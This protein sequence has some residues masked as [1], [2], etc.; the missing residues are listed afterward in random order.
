M[1]VLEFV[2]IDGAYKGR[3]VWARLNIVHQTPAAQEIA[4]GHLSAICRAVGVM[5]PRDSSELHNLPLNI[6]V[7]CKPR[8]DGDGLTN[9]IGR[10]EPSDGAAPAATAAPAPQTPQPTAAAASAVS[11]P[12]SN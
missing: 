6:Y 2:V 9:E 7:K 3:K 8:S 5:T 11:P 4:R 1:L 10:F 12:W